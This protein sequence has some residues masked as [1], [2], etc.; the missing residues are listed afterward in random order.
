MILTCSKYS[1]RIAPLS[2]FCLSSAAVGR[3]CVTF[4]IQRLICLM[5]N[6][7]VATLFCSQNV[8]C[9]V[10]AVELISVLNSNERSIK[11]LMGSKELHQERNKQVSAALQRKRHWLYSGLSKLGAANPIADLNS[12]LVVW[13]AE[14]HVASP[15][16]TA[17]TC[18]SQK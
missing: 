17:V 4:G 16:C 15:I 9:G 8:V 11:V 13:V 1:R 14:V 2:N 12:A 18:T 10:H 6:F 3:L 7:P 5:V